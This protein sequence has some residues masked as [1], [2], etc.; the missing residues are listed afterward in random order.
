MEKKQYT[1]FFIAS[2][3]ITTKDKIEKIAI[4]IINI[5]I[6]KKRI[7]GTDATVLLW[8]LQNCSIEL[9]VSPSPQTQTS[10]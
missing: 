5:V 1:L 7:G 4:M 10:Q 3:L 8:K 6:I 9:S 2:V